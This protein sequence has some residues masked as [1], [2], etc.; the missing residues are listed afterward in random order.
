MIATC[1]GIL[2]VKEEEQRFLLE[3]YLPLLEEITDQYPLTTLE[4]AELLE[5]ALRQTVEL[6]SIELPE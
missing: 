6:Y 4:K 3:T 5:S 1:S 2:G